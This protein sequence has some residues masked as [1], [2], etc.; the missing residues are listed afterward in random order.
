M[1]ARKKYDALAYESLPVVAELVKK[2]RHNGTNNPQVLGMIEGYFEDMYL[3]LSEI[4]RC[5]KEKGKAALVVSNVRFAGVT[6]PVD[7]ILAEIGRQVGLTI[8]NIFVLRYR[9]NSSQ[10]MRNYS[11]NPS[12]ESIV[13]WEKNA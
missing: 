13:V 4:S 12:R 3:A 5:L 1:E 9:G 2:I 10:Q 11:R 6:V 8:E 7:E